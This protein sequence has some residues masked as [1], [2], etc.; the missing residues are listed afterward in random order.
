MI[1]GTE[2]DREDRAL[3]AL[4]ASALSHD[5]RVEENVDPDRLPLLTE[6]KD[7]ALES[8]GTDFVQRLVSGNLAQ[9]EAGTPSEPEPSEGPA[10]VR[11]TLGF[12]CRRIQQ[13]FF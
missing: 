13:P 3:E 1:A 7:R 4:I 10:L 5:D 12:S 9:R 6:E 2:R 11:E 8:L